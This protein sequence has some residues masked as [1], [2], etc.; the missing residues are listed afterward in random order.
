MIKIEHLSKRFGDLEVLKD[1]NSVIHKG[2]IVAV[3]DLQA[4]GRSTSLALP[5][6]AG[7]TEWR[8]N[9]H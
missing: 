3:L 9:I 2:E 7:E 8:Q 4:P 5:Q 1:V 6:P